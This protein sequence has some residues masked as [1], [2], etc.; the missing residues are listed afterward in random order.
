MPVAP[1]LLLYLASLAGAIA[2]L[3]MMPRW[4]RST[5]VFGALI[6]AGTLGAL[7]IGLWSALRSYGFVMDAGAVPFYYIFSALAIGAAVLVIA[8]KKPVYS[9]LWFIMVVLA[10]AGLFLTLTAE[11]M[12]FAMVIIYGGAILVTYMF[13]IMLAAFSGDPEREEDLPEYDRE[14]RDPAAAVVFG[15]VLLAMLLTVAF[16]GGRVRAEPGPTDATIIATTLPNRSS[17]KLAEAVVPA[18]DPDELG[19]L[20]EITGGTDKN[21]TNTERVGL[22]LFE[23]HPLGIELAG[24][25]LTVALVGAVVIARTRVPEEP[26]GGSGAGGG[27]A[28]G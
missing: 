1:P 27:V 7:W 20:D 10:S 8:S 13:V 15:F 11:F 28:H 21:L 23:S 25:I 2:L 16:D 26:I 6:G 5:R 19:S 17:V 3:L 14:W 12:A 4:S 9:A 22:D 18:L 24:V